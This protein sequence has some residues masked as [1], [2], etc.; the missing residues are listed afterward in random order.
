MLIHTQNSW[1]LGERCAAVVRW[2]QDQPMCHVRDL[3][4]GAS[5]AT[6]VAASIEKSGL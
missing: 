2:M 3:H 4:H 1:L 6:R 5:F